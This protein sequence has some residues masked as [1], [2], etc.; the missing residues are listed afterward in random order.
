MIETGLVVILKMAL[1]AGGVISGGEA[2]RLPARRCGV[3][4]A[5]AMRQMGDFQTITLAVSD[6]IA[7]I[8]LNRPERLNAFDARMMREL[9]AAFD[10]TDKDDAVK[11]V[12]LT[13]AGER[14]FCAGADISMGAQAFDYD[15]RDPDDLAPLSE[16][17]ESRDGAGLVSLRIFDSL[18]PVIAAVN[19]AAVGAGATMILSADFRLAAET[20]RFAFV[21]NRRGIAPEAASS[22]FLPRLV[23]MPTALRWCYSG[24]FVPANEALEHGLVQSVHAQHELAAAATAFARSLVENSAPV[25]VAL[26]RQL[27]WRMLGASHPMEAH[28]FDSR[29]VYARG[30]QADAKEGIAAFLERR[31]AV[32]SDKVSEDLPDIWRGWEQPPFDI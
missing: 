7:T 8:T 12:V 2:M 28:R 9:I 6:A 26:T 13:G 30:S 10:R 32:F 18:K 25:S 14:A 11:A 5:E 21:F 17:G 4:R 1:T 20:A 19:G 16:R 23:G 3:R 31:A 27:M 15:R 29:A 24:A 22:W